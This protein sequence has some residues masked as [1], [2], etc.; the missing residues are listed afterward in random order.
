MAIHRGK[1]LSETHRRALA[2]ESRLAAAVDLLVTVMP[3][4]LM[5]RESPWRT[6][7]NAFLSTAPAQ[8]AEP[9]ADHETATGPHQN[10]SWCHICQRERELAEARLRECRSELEREQADHCLRRE[11]K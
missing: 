2:A 6:R 7:Y 8:A 3:S 5:A 4:D 11:P 1:L 10:P 9:A